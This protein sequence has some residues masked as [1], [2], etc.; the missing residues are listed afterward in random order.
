MKPTID[1]CNNIGRS[2]LTRK[3]CFLTELK[4]FNLLR[5]CIP[6]IALDYCLFL[7]FFQANDEI[8]SY[9]EGVREFPAMRL[10]A[11]LSR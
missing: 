10:E 7:Y 9:A 6:L 1:S 4:Q 3:D 11:E 5:Y 8:W 2:V